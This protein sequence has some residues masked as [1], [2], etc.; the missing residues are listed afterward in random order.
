MHAEYINH[1][2]LIILLL[3]HSLSFPTSCFHFF[4]YTA[5]TLLGANHMH[6]VWA[7]FWSV[8]SITRGCILKKLIFPTPEA[9]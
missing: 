6:M 5:L 9:L 3:S 8:V 7:T 2:Y 1:I 4:F